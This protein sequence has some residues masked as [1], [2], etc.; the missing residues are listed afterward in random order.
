MLA[1]IDHLER[2]APRPRARG[3]G[4]RRGACRARA[5]ADVD[6]AGCTDDLQYDP[7]IPTYSSVLGLPLGGGATGSASR[8]P[9][10]R[11]AGLPARGRACR[12]R[13][14]RACG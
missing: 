7:S 1:R 9:T 3:G 10:R 6:P 14:T 2:A 11:P 5:L 12:R 13:T 4:A 8:R